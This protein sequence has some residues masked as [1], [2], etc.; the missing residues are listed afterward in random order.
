MIFIT[1]PSKTQT[2]QPHHCPTATQPILL[3][4]S[5]ELI[6]LLRPL[7]VEE[8]SKLMKMSSKLGQS[9]ADRIHNFQPPLTEQNS[10]QAL[11]TFT[12]DAYDSLRPLEYSNEQLNYA[13]QSLRILSGLYGLLRPLDLMFPYRLEMGLKLTTPAGSTLYQFWNDEISSLLD[14]D[15]AG[16]KE[17]TIINLASTEYSKAVR[18]QLIDGF[19]LDIVFRQKKKESWATIPIH[20]KRARGAMIHYAITNEISTR[21]QLQSFD[22][23]GYRFDP[24]LS[25]SDNWVFLQDQ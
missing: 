2:P 8:L 13:Q 11:F 15:L 17:Q 23:N 18:P 14:R 24:D 6:K 16:H 19:W 25:T 4:K 3:D 12:G 1:S 7:S 21:E 20:A 10:N 5:E 9:T 22:L